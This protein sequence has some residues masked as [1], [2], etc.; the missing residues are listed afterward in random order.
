MTRSCRKSAASLRKK[1]SEFVAN[2]SHELRTPLT[3]I[4]GACETIRDNP[5]MDDE[6]R[7]FFLDMALNES[8]RMTRIV[9]DLLVLSRLDNKKTQWKVE[10]FD[11]CQSVQRIL[12]AMNSTIL[13]HNHKVSFSQEDNAIPNLTAD[14]ERIEQVVINLI[15]NAIKYT[16]DGGKISVV[17]TSS[18]NTITLQVIDNGIGIP[19]EDL[20]HIFERFF[21]VE[22]SR[23]SETGGT[24]LG[25]AIAKELIEAHQG[26]ISLDSEYG[27]G[28]TVTVT[29]PVSHGGHSRFDDSRFEIEAQVWTDVEGRQFCIHIRVD[30]R[31]QIDAC[32]GKDAQVAILAEVVF[33]V[34]E[35]L[36]E[37]R[38]LAFD[39]VAH[40][41]HILVTLRI[42]VVVHDVDVGLG[43][44][45]EHLVVPSEC[46]GT[47]EE[48]SVDD[49]QFPILAV[50]DLPCTRQ[51]QSQPHGTYG[52]GCEVPFVALLL[53]A[54]LEQA[55]DDGCVQRQSVIIFQQQDVASH[56]Q[57]V[58]CGG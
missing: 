3:S 33:L 42:R 44:V 52:V 35:Y 55:V 47:S 49:G 30:D 13:E 40:W 32:K 38:F 14:R 57:G 4:K 21:R 10:T 43:V 45:P 12:Y 27:R 56:T 54:L 23:T 25:L 48:S 58:G 37:L 1:Q 29:L 31:Y 36:F 17:V 2:V 22:K 34:L 46:V 20:S 26:T 41:Q 39:A 53:D 28:T 8:D 51:H 5:D 9:S 24:G 18:A 16:P 19:K 11:L 50:I 6:T 7:D 15:S